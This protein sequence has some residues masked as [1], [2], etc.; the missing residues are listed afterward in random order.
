MYRGFSRHGSPLWLKFSSLLVI[1]CSINWFACIP[2]CQTLEISDGLQTA[3]LTSTAREASG[4]EN[5][6]AQDFKDFI[7]VL[8]ALREQ[9][10]EAIFSPTV[11]AKAMPN[12]CIFFQCFFRFSGGASIAK[13]LMIF[14]ENITTKSQVG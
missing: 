3:S 14:Y 10:W 7:G 13:W 8:S 5:S 1:L 6:L 2:Y 11:L 12:V 9:F 4:R